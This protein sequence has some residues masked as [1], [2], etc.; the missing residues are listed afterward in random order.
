MPKPSLDLRECSFHVCLYMSNA[1]CSRHG[2]LTLDIPVQSPI[3][4]KLFKNVDSGPVTTT[5]QT[6]LNNMNEPAQVD[7]DT[8]LLIWLNDY[9]NKSAIATA[10][11]ALQVTTSYSLFPIVSPAKQCHTMF[12]PTGNQ[13]AHRPCRVCR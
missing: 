8:E 2:R 3:D 5:I 7:A 9:T 12:Y 11:A 4:P 6:A 13:G 1:Q 10:A